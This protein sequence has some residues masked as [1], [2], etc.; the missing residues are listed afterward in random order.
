MNR[1]PHRFMAWV[2]LALIAL[3]LSLVGL[4]VARGIGALP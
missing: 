4:I 1:N 3:A 2:A